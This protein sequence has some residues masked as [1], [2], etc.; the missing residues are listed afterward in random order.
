MMKSSVSDITLFTTER[1]SELTMI[2]EKPSSLAKLIALRIASVSAIS[3]VTT[4]SM[5][6][7]QAVK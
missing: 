4:S 7:L 3:G 6:L 1:Q 5:R 2:L